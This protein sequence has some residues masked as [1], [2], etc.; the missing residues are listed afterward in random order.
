MLQIFQTNALG[1][2]VPQMGIAK[3]EIKKLTNRAGVKSNGQITH[4]APIKDVL[5]GKKAVSEADQADMPYLEFD[6]DGVVKSDNVKQVQQIHKQ[7]ARAKQFYQKG[8][9]ANSE[10]AKFIPK[11]L[12]R[13]MFGLDFSGYAITPS[14]FNAAM[15]KAL[16]V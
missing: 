2:A 4:Y 16:K 6:K 5:S 10:V 9:L 15:R 13:I 8:S 1:V 14:E 11:N 3:I 7:E 12:G